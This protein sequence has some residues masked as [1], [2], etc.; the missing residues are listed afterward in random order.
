VVTIDTPER[1][2]R[3]AVRQHLAPDCRAE[4]VDRLAGDLVGIHATNPASVYLGAFARIDGLTQSQMESALYEDRSVLKFLGMRRT[5]FVVPRDLAAVINSAATRAIAVTERKRM[6]QLLHGAA[7]A[8]DVV[9][10]LGEVEAQPSPHS[11][12][13]AV[14]PPRS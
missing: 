7:V 11:T 4:S 13:W 12:S 3:I 14:R 6:V 5:M 10:W 9:A 1:R 2:R 8:D